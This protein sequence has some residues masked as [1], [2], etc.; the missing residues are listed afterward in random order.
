MSSITAGRV[1]ARMLARLRAG[2]AL[3]TIGALT[4]ICALTAAPAGA[5]TRGEAFA[6]T[7]FAFTR[8]LGVAAAQSAHADH[9]LVAHA[10][11]VEACVREHRRGRRCRAA[12]R[13]VQA[14]GSRL[15]REQRRLAALARSSS[16]AHSA[17]GGG[18]RQAP[19][20]SVSGERLSWTPNP[21][22]HRYLLV[23]TMPGQAPQ[24]WVIRGIAASPPPVPGVTADYRVRTVARWSAWSETRQIAYPSPAG[25]S[26]EAPGSPSGP[27]AP[28]S[29]SSPATP[30]PALG[31]T[32]AAPTIG[33]SGDTLT[34]DRV[35]GVETYVLASKLADGAETF[36]V[37]AG[38]STT[39]PPVAGAT[40]RYSVRTAVDGSAWSP[41]VAIA[42]PAE[43][44]HEAPTAPS[45][46]EAKPEGDDGAFQP[47]LVSGTNMDEDLQGA[48][49]LGAKVVR[50]GFSISATAAELEPVIA[51]YASKG[52]RVQP[53]AEFYGRMPSPA[54]AQGL[55]GWVRA[56]GPGGSFWVAHPAGAVP[57]EAI[58]FGNETDSGAQYGTHAGEAAYTALAETYATRFREAAQAVEA[59]GAE[60]GLLAEDDDETGDWMAGMY[61]AVPGLTRYVSGWTIHPYG[62]EQYNRER[63]ALLIAQ[64]AQRGAS[65][66]PIDITEW[67]VSTDNGDCVNFNEGLNPCMSYEEAAQELRSTVAW[68]KQMLGERLGDF[69]L[70][71][72]RDQKPAGATSNW[73]D[74]FGVLQHELQPKGAYTTAAQ[75]L[76]AS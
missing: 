55:A 46:G 51:G 20:L 76:L 25:S 57:I 14:S 29:P 5:H 38:T 56:F 8:A 63:L 67:G 75:E 62:G 3:T 48:V 66:I 10:K 19:A 54:E 26:P 69:F 47:G 37:V 17:S 64:T 60:V 7:P 27:A 71:Q 43:A 31:D 33:V 18:A 21:H 45:E 2:R 36:T 9:L 15:A 35:A 6:P 73:Q 16:A 52:I 24:L 4:T 28:G 34:W 11:A 41:E 72:V 61:A 58:E 42:Y 70:Y 30:P 74:Y 23:R 59:T 68:I 44:A 1:P 53:L 13:A 40:V 39:P 12:R 49:L 32:Q 50:V 22:V 65:K